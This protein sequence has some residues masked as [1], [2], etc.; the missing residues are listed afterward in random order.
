MK[1]KEHSPQR[2]NIQLSTLPTHAGNYQ[3]SEEL[4]YLN[5]DMLKNIDK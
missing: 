5:I 3:Y 2:G 4:L 1:C